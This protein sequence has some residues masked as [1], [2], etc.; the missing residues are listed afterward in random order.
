MQAKTRRR[1]PIVIAVIVAIAL[2]SWGGLWARGELRCQALENEYLNSV[3]VARQSV[4]LQEIAPDSRAL[5][6]LSA[7]MVDDEVEAAGRRIEAIYSECGEEAGRTAFRKGSAI[8][9]QG[10]RRGA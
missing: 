8:V 4:L 10:A 9:L 5:A 2:L 3:S 7:G 6:D 1:A